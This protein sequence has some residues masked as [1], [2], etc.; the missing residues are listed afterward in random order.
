MPTPTR[1]RKSSATSKTRKSAASSPGVLETDALL[2]GMANGKLLW[3]DMLRDDKALEAAAAA[4]VA[5]TSAS[6]VVDE[7]LEGW[8]IPDLTT[9]RGIWEHFPV[10]LVA[11]G[12][13]VAG[14]QRYAVVWHKAHLKEWREK[15]AASWDEYMEY[16]AFAE[17]RLLHALRAHG[18]AIEAPRAD[19]QIL[20]LVVPADATSASPVP[21]LVRLTDIRAHFPMVIWNR[22]EGAPGET[23]YAIA[24]RGDYRRR[25]DGREL[26]RTEAQLRRALAAS[27]F[28]TVLPAANRDEFVRIQMRHD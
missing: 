9:H 3:G 18:Y 6:P 8:S 2:K 23:T 4:P 7:M 25:V 21:P 12:R 14:K 1:K 10:S 13:P 22:V 19:D 27:R 28:W 17:Y 16:Q 15:R 24:I 20:V 11:L 5:A 26:A